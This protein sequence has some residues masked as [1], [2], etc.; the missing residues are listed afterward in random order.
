MLTRKKKKNKKQIHI[1]VNLP[2]RKNEK[3]FFTLSLG[4]S[5]F[6]AARDLKEHFSFIALTSS[7]SASTPKKVANLFISATPFFLTKG[8]KE[9]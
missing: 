7:S 1:N 3:L 9:N 5:A 4:I 2:L 8:E 6:S